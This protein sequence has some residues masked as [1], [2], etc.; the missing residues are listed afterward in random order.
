MHPS[1]E[2]YVAAVLRAASLAPRDAARV[3]DELL[4]HLDAFD[5][6]ARERKLSDQEVTDML[7]REFGNAQELGGMIADAKGRFRT[8]LKKEARKLPYTVAAAVVIALLIRW[9]AVESFRATGASMSPAIEEGHRFL[10]NKLAYRFGAPA[11]GDLVVFRDGDRAV[12]SRVDAVRGDEVR[13]AKLSPPGSGE[14]T[15]AAG[16]LLGRVCLVGR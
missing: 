11:E 1:V 9:Q 5:R 15:L 7:D 3:M 13:V 2:A 6:V 16:D 4:S 8:Y 12:V 10:V 14:R